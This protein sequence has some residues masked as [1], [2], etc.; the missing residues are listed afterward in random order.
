MD[1][2]EI[3]DIPLKHLLKPG[4]H[5]DKFWITTFPKKLNGQLVRPA[6]QDGQRVI[7]WGIRVNEDLNWP[8]ILLLIW[9][10]LITSGV[11]VVIYAALTS[12]S[13]SAF[14]LGAF[15]V[16]LLTVYVTYQYFAWKEEDNEA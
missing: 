6:G 3:A 8:Y 13:S 9:A 14:S 12:D 4:P 5:T 15:L 11:I 7:G 2:V 1:D 16:A 10:A